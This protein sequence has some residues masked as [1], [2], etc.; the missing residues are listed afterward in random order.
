VSIVDSK[1]GEDALEG[2]AIALVVE[3]MK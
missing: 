2:E 3:G 1:V